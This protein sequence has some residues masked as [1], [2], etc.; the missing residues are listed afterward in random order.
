MN[1][2]GFAANIL[3]RAR[4]SKYNIMLT[5]EEVEY[6]ITHDNLS[7]EEKM[8]WLGIVCI[9]ARDLSMSCTVDVEL[10]GDIFKLSTNQVYK[11]L[12]NLKQ[13]S[14]L[15]VALNIPLTWFNDLTAL[16]GIWRKVQVLDNMVIDDLESKAIRS[17]HCTIMLPNA[18]LQAVMRD[19]SPAERAREKTERTQAWVTQEESWLQ[20]IFNRYK[21]WVSTEWGFIR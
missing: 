12:F 4:K 9:S 6:V 18:G 14:F 10:L 3:R 7:L 20:E 16:L 8:L 11:A 15:Q 13:K 5:A 19:P 1:N 21:R 17:M 2:D